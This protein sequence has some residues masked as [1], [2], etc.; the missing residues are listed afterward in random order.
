CL[1]PL[2][3]LD[4]M[5][6]TTTEGIGSAARGGSLDPVQKSIA[7]N[8]GSQCGYCTPGWVMNLYS[9]LRANGGKPLTEEQLEAIC[10]GNLCRCTGYRPILKAFK[11]FAAHLC[12]TSKQA[13]FVR[14]E[15]GVENDPSRKAAFRAETL[16]H[17]APS[18]AG[19]ESDL[20][21]VTQCLADANV[22]AVTN[23]V[24]AGGQMQLRFD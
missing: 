18:G 20:R 23:G 19:R 22:A 24:V 15:S 6:I 21:V 11:K 5:A 1:R 3:S 13:S 9:F 16:L 17:P 10:D 2:C 14:G 7:E 12:G 4:G 8:N